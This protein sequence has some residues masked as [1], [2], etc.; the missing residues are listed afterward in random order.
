MSGT[1]SR[2]VLGNAAASRELEAARRLGNAIRDAAEDM[3]AEVQAAREAG[4]SWDAIADAVGPMPYRPI[5]E[6][7]T[8]MRRFYG[9]RA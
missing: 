3:R 9:E 8:A 5:G 6:S 2:H 4:A 1:T 7:A